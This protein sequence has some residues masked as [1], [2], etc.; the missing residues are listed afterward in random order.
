MIIDF[1]KINEV[2]SEKLQSN[3][4]FSAIRLDNTVGYILDC[5]FQNKTVS[6]DL[7]L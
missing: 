6:P 4:P 7:T 5:V 1:L 3:E 2:L